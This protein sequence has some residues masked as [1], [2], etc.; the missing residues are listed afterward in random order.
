MNCAWRMR[1]IG[2]AGLLAVAASACSGSVP[3]HAAAVI[4]DQQLLLNSQ[5]GY[6]HAVNATPGY[7]ARFAYQHA[8][9]CQTRPVRGGPGRLLD[10]QAQWA[11]RNHVLH[12]HRMRGAFN[13]T[14]S[15][16]INPFLTFRVLNA[17]VTELPSQVLHRWITTQVTGNHIRGHHATPW[18]T[19]RFTS[20]E[21]SAW[22]PFL[23]LQLWALST[24]NE[25]YCVASASIALTAA[26]G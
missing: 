9:S 25:L 5:P 22:T 6:A 15:S 24:H 11:Y 17:P 7:I 3:P 1:L 26:H 23:D 14:R 4:P 12:L 2:A 21:P 19:V 18:V 20:R 16:L 13:T 8:A 10:L